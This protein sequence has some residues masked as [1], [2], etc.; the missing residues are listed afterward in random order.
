MIWVCHFFASFDFTCAQF[1]ES[2]ALGQRLFC[3]LQ[4]NLLMS[5]QLESDTVHSLLHSARR[6]VQSLIVG[7]RADYSTASGLGP[8]ESVSCWGGGIVVD[9]RRV[10]RF[11]HFG[12]LRLWRADLRRR[13]C[14]CQSMK[15]GPLNCH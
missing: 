2:D 1:A 13:L 14:L 6:S 9:L 3:S 11:R 7:D 8:S 10:L 15:C 4:D 5:I 12:S